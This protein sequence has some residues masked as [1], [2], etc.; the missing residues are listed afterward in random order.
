[1]AVMKLTLWTHSKSSLYCCRKFDHIYCQV[2]WEWKHPMSTTSHCQ[3]PRVHE[4]TVHYPHIHESQ[5]QPKPARRQNKY[6]PP[7]IDLTREQIIAPLWLLLQTNDLEQ[8]LQAVITDIISIY[9]EASYHLK[10]LPYSYGLA[11]NPSIKFNWQFKLNRFLCSYRNLT[12]TFNNNYMTKTKLF[13][14]AVFFFEFM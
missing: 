8:N 3:C 13:M 10:V 2:A 11:T 14:Y 4:F 5:D 6:V 7:T 9:V 1:M 12:I